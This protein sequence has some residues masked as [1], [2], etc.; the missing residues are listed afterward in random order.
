MKG[1]FF[2]KVFMWLFIG[3]F[4]TFAC[5]YVIC[6]SN[7]L[8]AT[9][10]GDGVYLICAIAQIVLCIVLSARI[11][12]MQLTTAKILYI[13]YSIL[14]GITFAS[15]LAYFEVS[16]VI[17]VFLA[18]ALVFGIFAFIGNTTKMDLSK[19]G[20]YALMALIAVIIL[21][22]IN[23]FLLNST[24]S[25][26]V[27]VISIIAF[28]AFIAYDVQRLKSLEHFGVDEEEKSKYAIIGAFELY[29]DFINLFIDLLRLFG[30]SKD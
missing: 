15:I 27:I 29:L 10:A 14:T 20:T 19:I 24:I 23:L 28:I 6:S 4:I 3:L 12:K 18:T 7:S 1:D 11:H 17:Y 16:S 9:F 5:G 30:K 21:E 26:A 13:G 2:S 25:L 8:L 22:I